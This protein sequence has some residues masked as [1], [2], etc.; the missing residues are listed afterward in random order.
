VELYA[1][2]DDPEEMNDLAAELPEV[3]EALLA[4]VLEKA[5]LS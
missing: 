1:I 5:G 4:E 2:E 3:R